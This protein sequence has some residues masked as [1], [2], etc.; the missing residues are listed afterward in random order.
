MPEQPSDP[1]IDLQTAVTAAVATALS[2]TREPSTWDQVRAW[3]PAITMLIGAIGFLFAIQGDGALQAAALQRVEARLGAVE[4]E[5]KRSGEL[6]AR[7]KVLEHQ[8]TSLQQLLT[9][10]TAS[11]WT[12][13]Q[14]HSERERVDAVIAAL[15]T[16]LSALQAQCSPRN[17]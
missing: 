4:I 6:A 9:A 3:L 14:A 5:L 16:R 1:P 11:R 10:R 15:D 7:L 2:Q 12:A 8:A 17:R 13:A